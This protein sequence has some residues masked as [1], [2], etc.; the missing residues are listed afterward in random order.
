MGTQFT[1]KHGKT[2]GRKPGTRNKVADSIKSL[3]NDILPEDKLRE[4]WE[5]FIF[6]HPDA[7]IRWEAFKLANSYMFGKPA[8]VV[9]GSEDLP[10]VKIDI[11]A[12][13]MFHK[14]AT[15]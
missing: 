10:P 11:S 13:P 15:R 5:H 1:R 4:R 6:A 2:G 9:T 3:L 8:I 14:P 12:I 7:E